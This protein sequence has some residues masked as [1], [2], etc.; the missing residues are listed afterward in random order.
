M[1]FHLKRFENW[2]Q[3][4]PNDTKLQ[5]FLLYEIL[6]YAINFFMSTAGNGGQEIA[7]APARL[8]QVLMHA[9]LP[10]VVYVQPYEN[11]MQTISSRQF[12]FPT[13]CCTTKFTSIQ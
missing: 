2:L 8:K 3:R 6:Q 11:W 5:L 10:D 12:E 9:R 13:L 7:S 4:Y 1:C